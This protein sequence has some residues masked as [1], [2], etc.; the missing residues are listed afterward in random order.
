MN[1][2]FLQ[3]TN[4]LISLFSAYEASDEE[5][6]LKQNELLKN[7][8]DLEDSILDFQ[9]NYSSN[10]SELGYLRFHFHKLRSLLYK[11]IKNEQRWLRDQR[12]YL[13]YSMYAECGPRQENTET[14]SAEIDYDKMSEASDEQNLD[15]KILEEKETQAQSYKTI[16]NEGLLKSENLNVL[17]N[18]KFFMHFFESCDENNIETNA[19][20]KRVHFYMD[21][22]TLKVR[23]ENFIK[24]DLVTLDE[25]KE[26]L[27]A[28][29]KQLAEFNNENNENY[30]LSVQQCDSDTQNLNELQLDVEQ[31]FCFFQKKFILKSL[32][33]TSDE[34]KLIFYDNTENSR[35]CKEKYNKYVLL[36]HPD[37]NSDVNRSILTEFF[38]KLTNMKASIICKQLKGRNNKFDMGAYKKEGLNFFEIAMDYFHC[39]FGR[40]EKLKFLDIDNV[41]KID[42]KSNEKLAKFYF[43]Q[44]YEKFRDACMIADEEKHFEEMFEL[45]IFIS[46]CFSKIASRKLEAQLAALGCIHL[47]FKRFPDK[48]NDEHREKAQANSDKIRRNSDEK[49]EIQTVA[50]KSDLSTAKSHLNNGIKLFR[51]F[52]NVDKNLIT[53]YTDKNKQQHELLKTSIKTGASNL[54]SL[55]AFASALSKLFIQ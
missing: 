46:K 3:L 2:Q 13:Q 42:L 12:L 5:D 31:N 34:F 17:K 24:E 8:S 25:T 32:N 50:N 49:K 28:I 23:L 30:E 29:A 45:R 44:A 40:F 11:N 9:A 53:I 36:F 20:S 26:K 48:Y 35:T 47:V 14:N 10:K 38:V 6:A 15:F 37:K 19:D 41:D 4:E 39:S 33:L 51:E 18:K 54:T 55:V 21:V 27:A 1:K 22:S 43:E 7:L 16:L 52:L